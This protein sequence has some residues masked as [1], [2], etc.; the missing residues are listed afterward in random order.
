MKEMI[1][2]SGIITVCLMV[3]GTAFAQETD[4]LD[5]STL[6][7]NLNTIYDFPDVDAEF[8]GG[9]VSYREYIWANFHYPE[10]ALKYDDQG[11]I[12]LT[13]IVEIDGS[14]TGVEVMR[15]GLTEALNNAALKLVRDM[16]NWSPAQMNGEFVR[17]RCRLPITYRN[18]F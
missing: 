11:R 15:S 10:E 9:A 17:S 8:K 16:P 3:L 14:I 5:S 12:Y 2:K 1:I 4:T 18:C 6:P 13:F 7:L